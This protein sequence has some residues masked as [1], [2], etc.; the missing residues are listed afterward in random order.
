MS[1]RADK[2]GDGRTDGRTDAGNDNTRKPILASGKNVDE[3]QIIQ[4]TNSNRK[5]YRKYKLPCFSVTCF[6]KTCHAALANQC[7][8][9]NAGVSLNHWRWLVGERSLSYHMDR[10]LLC[11]FMGF[12]TI[13][14]MVMTYGNSAACVAYV[15]I[16]WGI[17]ATV[18]DCSAWFQFCL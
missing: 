16:W 7:A 4:G 2:L 18:L 3:Q 9:Y 11:N 15:R 17:Q 14:V 6:K 5:S 10:S 13:R 8:W 1:Y 12:L